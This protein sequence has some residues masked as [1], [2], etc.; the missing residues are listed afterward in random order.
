MMIEMFDTESK[1][2]ERGGRGA[3]EKFNSPQ[4]SHCYR[5]KSSQ[6]A[7]NLLRPIR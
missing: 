4:S 6:P 3:S 1:R 7:M 5:G 2:G